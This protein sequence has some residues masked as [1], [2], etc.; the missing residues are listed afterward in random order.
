MRTCSPVATLRNIL[1]GQGDADAYQGLLESLR[2]F[3]GLSGR[4]M[5]CNDSSGV[6]RICVME[7]S[8]ALQSSFSSLRTHSCYPHLHQ[9][10][11]TLQYS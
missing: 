8:L 7:A 11:P 3:R 5:R 1:E 2:E 4:E 9:R 10:N 6:C